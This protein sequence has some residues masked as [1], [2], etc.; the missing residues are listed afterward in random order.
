MPP[1]PL[2]GVV[3][4]PPLR[5]IGI[6]DPLPLRPPAP[7]PKFDGSGCTPVSRCAAPNRPRS[8]ARSARGVSTPSAVFSGQS[9]QVSC[10]P[11]PAVG[12][13]VFLRRAAESIDPDCS[14]PPPDVHPDSSPRIFTLRRFTLSYSRTVSRP[15]LPPCCSCSAASWCVLLAESRFPGKRPSQGLPATTNRSVRLNPEPYEVTGFPVAVV[16]PR[17]CTA[18]PCSEELRAELLPSS[19]AQN[20]V[21]LA[22]RPKGNPLDRHP[23]CVSGR[24]VSRGS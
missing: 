8:V 12:F 7:L 16:S 24:V 22:H 2:L 17:P 21:A 15:P 4:V 3:S 13:E 14:A 5:R 1:L 23:H 11:S 19:S 10:N 6:F 18:D 20:L 9:P